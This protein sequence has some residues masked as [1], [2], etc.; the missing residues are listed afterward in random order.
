MEILIRE[1]PE[2]AAK[3]G[4]NV[5]R[6]IIQSKDKPVLGLAT[7]DTPLRMYKEVIRM[8]QSSQLS[9]RNFR[10]F[11]ALSILLKLNYIYIYI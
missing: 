4:A 1:S 7:G 8:Y 11:R 9:L 10:S 3:V 5:V 6:K 2:A